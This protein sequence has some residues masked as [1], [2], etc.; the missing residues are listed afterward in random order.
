MSQKPSTVHEWG[1]SSDY[2]VEP[3]G[4][5]KA[6][7]IAPGSQLPAHWFN[8]ILNNLQ[9]WI[10]YLNDPNT[11]T[12]GASMLSSIANA[13][14]TRLQVDAANH[15][16]AHY[17]LI[18][19]FGDARVYIGS[20]TKLALV[21]VYNA[22]QNS[23]NQ[24]VKITNSQTATALYIS[25][26]SVRI[27]SMP[28]A[29]NTAWT[30]AFVEGEGT[31]SGWGSQLFYNADT[32][33]ETNAESDAAERCIQAP[34]T[35]GT[36]RKL[37]LHIKRASTG[38]IRVYYLTTGQGGLEI[39]VNAGWTNS[40][41]LWAL[42]LAATAMKLSI[43]ETQILLRR[44]NS[45]SAASTFN[46]SSWDSTP[47]NFTP[48][49]STSSGAN[50]DNTLNLG[51]GSLRFN[52]TTT[53]NAEDSN[54]PSTAAVPTNTLNAKA[55]CKAWGLISVD[56]A[57]TPTVLDG[58]NIGSVS[59]DTGADTVT[60]T[61]ATNMQSANYAVIANADGLALPRFVSIGSR[62][63]SQ[64]SF[65]V[66]NLEND[67]TPING[68]NIGSTACIFQFAVFARQDS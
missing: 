7:G 13:H 6:A 21:L 64:V 3:S 62:S 30:D 47:L 37:L 46:D 65:C 68:V 60:I 18:A 54:P 32:E 23:S 8:W 41:D 17:T 19:T 14:A 50:D 63:T 28:A 22:T 26:G 2:L 20:S 15:A 29:Q 51:N 55:I 9:S 66:W 38:H 44:K 1:G 45:G 12:I 36:D 4:G 43:T 67:A 39:T 48:Q 5:Q 24:W 57:G 42:D 25:R 16:T 56:A 59:S 27:A 33:S 10:E 11:I 58:M 31:T 34:T 40:T 35:S 49:S 52:N 61:F 53:T